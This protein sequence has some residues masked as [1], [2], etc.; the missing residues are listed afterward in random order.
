MLDEYNWDFDFSDVDDMPLPQPHPLNNIDQLLDIPGFT[1]AAVDQLRQKATIFSYDTNVVANY[2]SDVSAN[3]DLENAYRPGDPQ[4]NGASVRQVPDEL[5]DSDNL[6]DLR[7]DVS[8][9]VIGGTLAD[10]RIKAEEMY[11]YVR[12]HLPRPLYDKLTLPTV[13]R[14][15]RADPADSMAPN[16][17]PRYDLEDPA[18]LVKLLPHRDNAAHPY[19]VGEPGPRADQ[20]R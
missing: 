2:I 15:G 10:Y 7:F 17:D 4:Y 20:R 3:A 5:K 11:A 1:E 8:R 18:T 6:A 13:D 19:N 16:T 12:E 9:Y 14:L